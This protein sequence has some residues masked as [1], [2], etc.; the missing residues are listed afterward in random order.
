M[1]ILLVGASGYARHYLNALLAGKVDCDEFFVVDPFIERSESLD[2]LIARGIKIYAAMEDFYA[3]NSADLAIV[4]TPISLHKEHIETAMKNGSHCLCEKPLCATIDEALEIEQIVSKSGK[5]L[6]VG[7]QWSWSNI[8]QA[9][10]KDIIAGEFGS[11]IMLKT[12]IAWKRGDK[13]YD[14]SGWKGKVKDTRGNWLLD[15]V[16][17]N[18]TAH[19][20]HNIFFLT[21]D[22]ML[23]ANTPTS[24]S[25][26]VYRGRDIESFD[27]CLLKGSLDGGGE[28]LF[29]A[30]HMCEETHNPSFEYKFE[31]GTIYHDSNISDEVYAKFNNGTTKNYSALADPNEDFLKLYLMVNAVQNG[32]APLCTDK[33]CVPHIKVCNGIFKD[34]KVIE[35]PPELRIKTED[36]QFVK[37]FLE[38]CKTAYTT[39]KLDTITAEF[40]PRDITHFDAIC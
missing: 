39:E 32:G 15:S 11:P 30:T 20:L 7:F 40:D 38:K 37:G 4:S 23:S 6:G 19:Y 36:G 12:L 2:T 10:K 21:G 3:N 16:V 27:T 34:F 35:A 9:L 31:K 1:K 33:T 22:D 5:M 24:V 14:K 25:G 26:S 28:F 29:A 8:M 17:T 18:A 13:Y